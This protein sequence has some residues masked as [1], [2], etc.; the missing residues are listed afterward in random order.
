MAYGGSQA[1]CPIGAADADLRHSH[2]HVRSELRLQPTPQ[3]TAVPNITHTF[4][5]LLGGKQDL[6]LSDPCTTLVPRNL[7]A[8]PASFWHLHPARVTRPWGAEGGLLGLGRVGEHLGGGRRAKG[9]PGERKDIGKGVEEG[10][11]TVSVEDGFS[12]PEDCIG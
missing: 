12:G 4:D 5:F 7:W 11:G 3:L 2:S 1:R 8:L 6:H 10:V 9:T